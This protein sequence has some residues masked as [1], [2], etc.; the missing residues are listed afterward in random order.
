MRRISS[1][2]RRPID[3]RLTARPRRRCPVLRP[4]LHHPVA[5]TA[6]AWIIFK[7]V[8]WLGLPATALALGGVP[9]ATPASEPPPWGII[10]TSPLYLEAPPELLA[11]TPRPDQTPLWFFAVPTESHVRAVL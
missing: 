11:A 4:A 8:F 7:V 3:L 2:Q 5:G 9:G 6:V 1:P 10:E